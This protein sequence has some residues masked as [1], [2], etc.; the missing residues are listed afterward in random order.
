MSASAKIRAMELRKSLS[1]LLL[2]AGSTTPFTGLPSHCPTRKIDFEV[3]RKMLIQQEKAQVG[4]HQPW[5]SDAKFVA[6]AGVLLADRSV[7]PTDVDGL[8]I[9]IVD[10]SKMK[11]I[12]LFDFPA[13]KKSYRV[14][15]R[16]FRIHMPDSHKLT[17]TAWW[18]TNVIVTD[19]AVQS[20]P[21]K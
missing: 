20:K 9:H 18:T 11:A 14:T 5:R 17:T 2:L 13:R 6:R 12:F 4:G 7:R 3:S 15:V 1:V 19:C 21:R 16:R 10:K 8:P